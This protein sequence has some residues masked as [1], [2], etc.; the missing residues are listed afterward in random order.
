MARQKYRNLRNEEIGQLIMQGCVCQDWNLVEVT[1]NFLPES[2]K[3][4][5]FSGHIKIGRYDDEIVLFG[6]VRAKTGIYNAY[7]HNCTVSDN[8]LISNVKSYIANYNIGER[9]VIHNINQLA[10]EGR[11][12]FGN[13]TVVKVINESGGREIPIYDHLSAH[14]AYILAL[15][16][17]R[18]KAV[19]VLEKFVSDYVSFISDTKG[20]VGTGVKIINCDS[21]RN[22]KIGPN[23]SLEGVAKLVNGSIN[24]SVS[25]PVFIGQ[26]VIMENFIVCSGSRITDSTLISNC[27]VGQGCI[28]DKHYSAVDSAFFANCQGFHGEATSIFAG[29]YTVSHHKSSL[30]IAGMFSFMNAGSG[31]NQSNH[32]YK[33]GP[34]HQ[35]VVERGAK[36]TSDSYILWPSRIGAFSLVMGRHY[37]HSDTTNFPFSYLIE[38]GGDSHLVPGINLQSIGTIRD[39]QKWPMRDRRKDTN[40]LD[41]INFNLLSPYTIQKMINGRAIL[42]ELVHAS[43]ED[44]PFYTYQGMV[45]KN[46]ALKRGIALYEKAIWKFLGNS[47]ITRLQKRK[48]NTEEDIHDVLKRDTHMGCGC[49]WFDIAGLISPSDAIENLMN[50]I[51]NQTVHSLE[52]VNAVIRTIHANYYTYEWSWTVYVLEQF[53]GKKTDALSALDIIEIVN[54]WKIAVLDID[55][56][57]YGD[58]RKEFAMIKQTGFGVDGDNTIRQLDFESV[59]G[60]FETHA[61]VS[62]I[63]DH[64]TKKEALGNSIIQIMEKIAQN[65]F[66][67][68]N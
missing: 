68:N 38:E 33:L 6:G 61:E 17:H 28:L 2:V 41:L 11:S 5:T 65:R 57:L 54:K 37:R 48:I 42:K 25:D 7:L 30:L 18:R 45:V 40:L 8:V 20:E 39:S 27:F 44:A 10:V 43:G 22:V 35:G 1:E 3:K 63:R 59:R 13:G 49:D 56:S 66:I 52:E 50:S 21:I 16:R 34:I 47:V 26:G 32:L 12:S 58:A 53:Y 29:P 9:V 19:E 64:M 31:S 4:S 67:L 36:T 23:A 24:S 46:S 60:E 14:V 55:H 51:E 15:Y 62:S